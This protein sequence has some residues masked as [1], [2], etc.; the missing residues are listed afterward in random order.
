VSPLIVNIVVAAFVR[1]V[2]I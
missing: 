2:S 1:V